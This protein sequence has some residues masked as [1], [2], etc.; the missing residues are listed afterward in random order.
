MSYHAI[1]TLIVLS[2]QVATKQINT[3]GELLTL[4][5]IIS[6]SPNFT[7]PV[8]VVLGEKEFIFCGGNC[9]SPVDQLALTVLTFNPAAS[10]GLQHYLVPNTGHVINA[11]HAAPRAFAQMILFLNSNRIV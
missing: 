4:A 9:T 2:L 1:L 6:P 8:N 11:H 10:N 5:G 7:G 3:F